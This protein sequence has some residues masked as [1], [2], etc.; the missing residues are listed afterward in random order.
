MYDIIKRVH[1]S[2]GHGGKDK[3]LKIISVTYANVIREVVELFKSLYTECMK[4]RKRKC[5]KGVVVKPIISRDYGS[6]GQVDLIDMQS[7]AYGTH[8]WIMVYQV[9]F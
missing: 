1:L 7:M 9:I 4:K 3:M 5:V 8:K 6:R 2:T